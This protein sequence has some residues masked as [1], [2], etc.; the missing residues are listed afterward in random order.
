M[1]EHG[2]HTTH[3]RYWV[4]LVVPMRLL[5]RYVVDD[6]RRHIMRAEPPLKDGHS[7]DGSITGKG[8]VVEIGQPFIRTTPVAENYFAG[9]DYTQDRELGL[10]GAEL[11]A[12]ILRADG[13][14]VRMIET[15]EAQLQECYDALVDGHRV[16]FKT[17]AKDTGNLF[18]QIQ[19][20]GHKATF[21]GRPSCLPPFENA[22]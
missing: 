5:C 2:I 12:R 13:R 1:I 21:G 16:E 7:K 17:E 10:R 15:R 19:E 6:M 9:F 14:T 22:R 4:H 11:I 20:G 18:V 8:Y 3:A